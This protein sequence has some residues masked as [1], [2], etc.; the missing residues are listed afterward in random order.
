MPQLLN[1]VAEAEPWNTYRV[2]DGSTIRVKIVLTRIEFKGLNDNG[3]PD[4]QLG[5][6]QIVDVVPGEH[7]KDTVLTKKEPRG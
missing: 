6:Q 5:F 4:Y 7:L 2:E 1:Y 3:Q